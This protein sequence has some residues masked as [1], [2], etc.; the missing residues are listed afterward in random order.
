MAY[1]D[2]KEEFRRVVNEDLPAVEGTV[3]DENDQNLPADFLERLQD[4]FGYNIKMG[5]ASVKAFFDDVVSK[6]TGVNKNQV[7]AL[8][9]G[10]GGGILGPGAISEKG[11]FWDFLAT[12]KVL[13]QANTIWRATTATKAYLEYSL[14]RV[15][16]P[17]TTQ[18]S[19]FSLA[20]NEELSSTLNFYWPTPIAGNVSYKIRIVV[21]TAQVNLITSSLVAIK[22][23][24]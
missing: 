4:T 15:N 10:T 3:L 12:D 16:T 24:I 9:Q 23:S 5:Y 1:P 6:I 11:A 20:A 19:F 8:Y 13:F 17:I 21:R 7:I 22:T 18:Y 14:L 2:D